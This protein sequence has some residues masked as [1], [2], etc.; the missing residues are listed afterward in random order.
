MARTEAGAQRVDRPP[1]PFGPAVAGVRGKAALSLVPVPGR[2][3]KFPRS[4]SETYMPGLAATVSRP[5]VM[6]MEPSL[7]SHMPGLSEMFLLTLPTS[8][9]NRLP[10]NWLEARLHPDLHETAQHEFRHAFVAWQLGVPVLQ[11]SVEPDGVSWGRTFVAPGELKKSQIIS[12]AGKLPTDFGQA[13]GTSSDEHQ[14]MIG[15]FYGGLTVQEAYG[16]A[17]AAFQQCSQEVAEIAVRMITLMRTVSGSEFAQI[18]HLA[19]Q[20]AR[21]K[22]VISQE[23][24]EETR[25]RAQFNHKA[26]EEFGPLPGKTVTVI[27]AND[28]IYYNVVLVDNGAKEKRRCPGCGA[29]GS[30]HFVGCQSVDVELIPGSEPADKIV[31]KHPVRRLALVTE[32]VGQPHVD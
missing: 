5:T 15:S 27:D 22:N 13:K 20:V 1:V 25:L 7:A 17:R 26:A 3:Y 31:R 18:M 21:G 4:Q 9:Q 16:E 12:M 19:A 2:D 6:P 10:T 11:V 30:T 14:A 8:L 29:T 23:Q 32:K 28:A 24:Y